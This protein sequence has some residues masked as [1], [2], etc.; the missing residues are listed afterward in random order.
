M[1]I[2][3]LLAL[4]LAVLALAGGCSKDD[5][6]D[7]NN[8]NNNNCLTLPEAPT[9]TSNSPVPSGQ[10]LHLNAVANGNAIYRWIAPNGEEFIEQ[11]QIIT[12]TGPTDA[13]EYTCFVIVDGCTSEIASIN[14][15]VIPPTPPCDPTDNTLDAAVDV[16]FSQVTGNPDAD[17]LFKITADGDHG[18]LAITFAFPKAP[19]PGLYNIV[20]AITP[21]DS[22]QPEDVR[23]SFTTPGVVSCTYSPNSGDLYVTLVDSQVV[24]TLCGITFSS[25]DNGCADDVVTGRVVVQ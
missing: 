21:V 17:S 11:D 25:D 8:N 10:A 22:L 6:G 16:V 9:L 15:V 20:P 13:G 14:V 7:N 3:K 12:L 23:V 2:N 1:R 19:N 18:D 24:V 4:L 5:D